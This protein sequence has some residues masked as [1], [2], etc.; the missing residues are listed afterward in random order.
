[1]KTIQIL[2]AISVWTSTAIADKPSVVDRVVTALNQYFDDQLKLEHFDA[3]TCNKNW[4]CQAYYRK[5]IL[6]MFKDW[7]S[8]ISTLQGHRA[9]ANSYIKRS[10][11]SADTNYRTVEWE[12]LNPDSLGQPRSFAQI[13]PKWPGFPTP[14]PGYIDWRARSPWEQGGHG[15]IQDYSDAVPGHIVP[16]T[17][18]EVEVTTKRFFQPRIDQYLRTAGLND[19]ESFK[20][21]LSLRSSRFEYLEP[22]ILTHIRAKRIDVVET[23]AR[24]SDALGVLLRDLDE[25]RPYEPEK[26]EQEAHHRKIIEHFFRRGASA[27]DQAHTDAIYAKSP[28]LVSDYLMQKNVSAFIGLLDRHAP[29]SD[30]DKFRK[31]VNH[32]EKADDSTLQTVLDDPRGATR[33]AK[34]FASARGEHAQRVVGLLHHKH[35]GTA[36]QT[37]FSPLDPDGFFAMIGL[38]P[39]ETDSAKIA[40]A[41]SVAETRASAPARRSGYFTRMRKALI[42]APETYRARVALLAETPPIQFSDRQYRSLGTRLMTEPL[43]FNPLKEFVE[44]EDLESAPRSELPFL[45]HHFVSNGEVPKP[46]AD[47]DSLLLDKHRVIDSKLT[48][49]QLALRHL[50]ESDLPSIFERW[51]ESGTT[52]IAFLEALNHDHPRYRKQIARRLQELGHHYEALR[53][54]MGHPYIIVGRT[55]EGWAEQVQ[56]TLTQIESKSPETLDKAVANENLFGK[57]KDFA[58]DPKRTEFRCSSAFAALMNAV[59]KKNAGGAK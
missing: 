44:N 24:D 13:R 11:Y 33:Y 30:P 15:R 49:L 1:M 17:W 2:L 41:I 58:T 18:G 46:L 21:E 23:Q 28:T 54:L 56:D 12:E 53:L 25:Y 14:D 42:D 37:Q 38:E 34:W 22:A 26:K 45:F 59:V 50:T 36:V 57:L 27:F 7:R 16:M 39:S 20:E 8:S 19:A 4:D 5:Q 29:E 47:R 52:E 55:Y 31:F 40:Q 48:S 3:V 32:L 35:F 9:V 6:Q 43:E 10:T 51:A